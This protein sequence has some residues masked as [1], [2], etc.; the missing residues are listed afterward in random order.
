[1]LWLFK[2]FD[3]FKPLDLDP[4]HCKKISG[5]I[6]VLQIKKST[7]AG[8]GYLLRKLFFSII[9]FK[10]FFQNLYHYP[11]PWLRIQ[12]APKFRIRIRIQCIWIHSTDNQF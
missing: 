2:F 3:F 11:G 8:I 6:I 12:I 9:I 4:K 10:F 5:D 1:M 7:G